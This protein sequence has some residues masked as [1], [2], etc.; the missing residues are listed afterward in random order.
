M[1]LYSYLTLQ[2]PHDLLNR[3]GSES[4]IC[5]CAAGILTLDHTCLESRLMYGRLAPWMFYIP[6]NLSTSQD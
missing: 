5:V 6:S 4:V 1:H 3:G 2:I